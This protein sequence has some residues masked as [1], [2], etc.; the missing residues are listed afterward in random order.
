M[1]TPPEN[2]SGTKILSVNM[3]FLI[4]GILTTNKI[5]M[6]YIIRGGTCLTPVAGGL[7]G[8]LV[9]VHCAMFT[10]GNFSLDDTVHFGKPN[11]YIVYFMK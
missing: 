11:G 2:L 8:C 9:C 10:R 5:H 4:V 3:V 7:M 1:E 6:K